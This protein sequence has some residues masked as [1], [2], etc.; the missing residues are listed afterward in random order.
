MK[1]IGFVF[2]FCVVCGILHAEE[3]IV[4]PDEEVEFDCP[5]DHSNKK[6]LMPFPYP[7]DKC[8]KPGHLTDPSNYPVGVFKGRLHEIYKSS[9]INFAGKYFVTFER[10]GINDCIAYY[11]FDL[12]TGKQLFTLDMFLNDYPN[13]KTNDGYTYT[14]ELIY[15]PN[16]RLL[17]AQY[18]VEKEKKI[19]K[20]RDYEEIVVTKY[21]CRERSFI[22]ENEKLKPI[23]KTRKLCTQWPF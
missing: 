23:S 9:E 15:W 21:E 5:T 4:L 7:V 19:V 3:G 20:Y 6:G 13:T 2:F 10:C 22:L 8:L 17:V 18:W 1:S 16:S 11:L 12:T 14:T